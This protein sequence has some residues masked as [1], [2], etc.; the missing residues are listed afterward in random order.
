MMTLGSARVL[1]GMALLAAVLMATILAHAQ[2][3]DQAQS[4]LGCSYGPL[5]KMVAGAEWQVF[6]CDGADQMVLV[7]TRSNPAF[8]SYV[9]FRWRDGVLQTY[10]EGQGDAKAREAARVEVGRLTRT[11]YDALRSETRTKG[12]SQPSR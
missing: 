7:A 1:R 8:F 10:A 5:M 3:S 6:S 4:P 2:S 12:R 9:L 11:E